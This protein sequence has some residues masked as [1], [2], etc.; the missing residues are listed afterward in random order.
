[1]RG[2]LGGRQARTFGF[3]PVDHPPFTADLPVCPGVTNLRVRWWRLWA[4]QGSGKAQ[5]ALADALRR[6]EFGLAADLAAADVQVRRAAE[7]GYEPAQAW[8]GRELLRGDDRPADPEQGVRWLQAAAAQDSAFAMVALA[9][10][11]RDGIG[12]VPDPAVAARWYA[13]AK[14]NGFAA[15][16]RP[17]CRLAPEGAEPAECA[18]ANQ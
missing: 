5:M 17:L 9:I 11:V 10:A 7:A 3:D 15:A 12:V 14:A 1:M 18:A 8:L 6:G 16:A 2:A 13:L 4:G